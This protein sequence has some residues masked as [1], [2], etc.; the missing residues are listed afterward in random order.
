MHG[1]V[2]DNMTFILSNPKKQAIRKLVTI[3]QKL[4][5]FMQ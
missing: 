5:L 2:T 3:A 1:N 4:S